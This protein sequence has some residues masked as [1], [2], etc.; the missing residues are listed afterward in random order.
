MSVGSLV[1][2][3]VYGL[4]PRLCGATRQRDIAL[5]MDDGVTL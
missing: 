2:A 5:P 3:R 1:L 4:P